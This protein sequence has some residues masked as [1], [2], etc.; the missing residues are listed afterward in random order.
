M[1][2]FAAEYTEQAM[3]SDWP[4]RIFWIA[5][6]VLC[7]ALTLWLVRLGWKHRAKRHADLPA[8]D[9]TPISA[10]LLATGRYLGSAVAGN[11]LD[12]ITA[13]G[14]GSTSSATLHLDDEVLYVERPS[15]LSFRI[16]R[17]SI[18]EVRTD[19]GLVGE[20]YGPDGIVV[21][22][23]NWGNVVM[24][25]GFRGDPVTQNAMVLAGLA[26]YR[27]APTQNGDRT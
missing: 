11:W 14:L 23:W 15:E 26:Q 16:P 20:V 7:V 4:A 1:T 18:I 8:L 24:D 25:T 12:R 13:H 2:L 6:L 21:V 17:T 10:E 27:I 9:R 22:Q 19:R 5:V 3:V